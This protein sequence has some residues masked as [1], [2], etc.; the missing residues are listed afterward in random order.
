LHYQG[1]SYYEQLYLDQFKPKTVYLEEELEEE[2][3]WFQRL[4]NWLKR[5]F[6]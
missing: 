2:L 5:L 6:G 3:S 1:D 4:I